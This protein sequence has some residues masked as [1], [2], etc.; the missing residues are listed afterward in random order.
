RARSHKRRRSTHDTRAW[1]VERERNGKRL[2]TDCDQTGLLSPGELIRSGDRDVAPD[3]SKAGETEAGQCPGAES[4]L[5]AASAAVQGGEKINL[6]LL[7]HQ[8]MPAWF[9]LARPPPFACQ[10]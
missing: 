9:C 3:S 8:S 10:A 4:I 6:R 5:I 2:K 1:S 7:R